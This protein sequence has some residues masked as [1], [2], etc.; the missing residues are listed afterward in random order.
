MK[1]ILLATMMVFAIAA[2][3]SA[4]DK[5][6]MKMSGK[7]KS[8]DTTNNIF[9][10]ETVEQIPFTFAITPMTDFEYKDRFFDDAEFTDIVEDVWVE[11]KYFPGQKIHTADEVEIFEE[12]TN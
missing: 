7:V 10:V 1:K 11:V 3:A 9:V 5:D 6:D 12:V 8:I 4:K 2:T